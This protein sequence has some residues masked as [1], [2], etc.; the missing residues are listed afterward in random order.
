[1]MTDIMAALRTMRPDVMIEF[2]QA[3]IG[4]LIRKYGNMLRASDSPNSYLVNRT[5]V[6]DVR[7]LSGNTP[8]H[9]DM[10]MWHPT[11]PPEIAAFQLNNVLFSV[12]QVSVKLAT[13][14]AAH[15]EMVRYYLD[16][17]RANR[18]LLI[19]GK[20]EALSPN[21]NYPVVIGYDAQKQIVGLYEDH[22]VRLDAHRPNGRIDV[23]NGK[24]SPTVTLSAPTDLGAYRFTVTD[25]RGRIVRRGN[26][27]LSKGLHELE[28][29]VSGIIALER[30]GPAVSR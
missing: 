21:A 14:S 2:R 15:R 4:P 29:P 12:P 6:V 9:A 25:C 23:V 11:E 28:V 13:A 1:M 27:S 7:M 18:D 5:K 20:L 8:V 3:Y 16:Y 24:S 30:T 22:V 26:V 19:G 17:W 10:V